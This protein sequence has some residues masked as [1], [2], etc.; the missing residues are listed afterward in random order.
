[1]ENKTNLFRIITI[2]A[3]MGLLM[4]ACSDGG[5]S[6]PT[7]GVFDNSGRYIGTLLDWNAENKSFQPGAQVLTSKGYIVSFEADSEISFSDFLTTTGMGWKNNQSD[8]ARYIY[9]YDYPY[10]EDNVL[11]DN[12]KYVY[13]NSYDTQRFWIWDGNPYST[14][15][16]AGGFNFNGSEWSE[17]TDT[18][19]KLTDVSRSTIGLPETMDFPLYV[20]E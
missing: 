10:E 7:T 6:I 16:I 3:V 19:Y 14:I 9:Y 11:E 15:T 2:T 20:V 1:M 5:I 12:P 13:F 18:F 17:D 4:A 8:S